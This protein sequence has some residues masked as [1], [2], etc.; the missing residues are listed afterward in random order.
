MDL[1]QQYYSL[2]R[3]LENLVVC[4]IHAIMVDNYAA[5]A[6]AL[7]RKQAILEELTALKGSVDSQSQLALEILHRI[8]SKENDACR[9]LE[10]KLEEAQRA[11]EKSR[12]E[13]NTR[14]LETVRDVVKMHKSHP[15]A[16]VA[17]SA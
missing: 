4:Q 17:K 16:S 13:D 15:A 3:G 6:E 2:L 7:R 10:L 14:R 9:A 5:L 8:Q 12:Q 1:Y 11:I